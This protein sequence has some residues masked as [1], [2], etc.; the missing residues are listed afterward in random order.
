MLVSIGIIL[1]SSVH[2]LVYMCL[3]SEGV[4]YSILQCVVIFF[5]WEHLLT[6]HFCPLIFTLILGSSSHNEES[7]NLTFL[8]LG[9]KG[10]IDTEAQK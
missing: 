3:F 4:Y 1:L 2:V 7:K 5:L 9:Y 8:P 10:L 6:Y